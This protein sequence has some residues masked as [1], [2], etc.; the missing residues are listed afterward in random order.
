MKIANFSVL[1]S[2]YSKAN[3]DHFKL[4]LDSLFLQTLMPSDFVIV[5]DGPITPELEQQISDFKLK[6]AV[7]D[8]I[9]VEIVRLSKNMGLG[10]AL[11]IGLEYCR[12]NIVARFDSDDICFVNRF[13]KQY[14]YFIKN[15]VDVLGTFMEEFNIEPKDKCQYHIQPINHSDILKKSKYLN[16]ICH[17]TVMFNKMK[18]IKYGSYKDM[19]L[20]EDFFLWIR[21]LKNGLIFQN[22]NEP[23]VYFRVGDNMIS[24]R[25]GL[26]YFIHEFN[27]YRASFTIGHIN[28]FQ[29][30]IILFGKFLI[31]ILP[32]RMLAVIYKII[33]RRSK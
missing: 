1:I 4:A 31:R 7:N 23:L 5:C 32:S 21:L 10:H 25:S 12:H 9:N 6:Y 11:N 3:S 18:V 20:F 22:L 16:P 29:F 8:K 17:P 33:S 14:L 28:I 30:I 19:P 13:E 2:I 27:F 26:K 15:E 24:R